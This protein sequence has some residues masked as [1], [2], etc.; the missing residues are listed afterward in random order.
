MQYKVLVVDDNKMNLK[1]LIAM[2]TRMGHFVIVAENGVEAV[3]LFKD[4][5]FHMILMDYQMPIMDGE[6]ATVTIRKIEKQQKSD[7][8]IP[9]IAVSANLTN[10][11]KV[12]FLK[13]GVD[14]VI[15]KPIAKENLIKA[16]KK[17][18]VQNGQTD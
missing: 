2:L 9:I 14:D 7:V 16:I 18:V 3:N 15:T 11:I 13:S 10:E 12:S 5:E 4:N 6:E 1:V 8:R 17:H